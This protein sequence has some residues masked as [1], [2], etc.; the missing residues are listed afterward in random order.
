MKR[1]VDWVP[2]GMMLFPLFIGAVIRTL[3]PTAFSGDDAVFQKSFTGG[4]LTGAIPL[5]AAFY[6]CLGST[7]EFRSTGYI[8]RK[9]GALWTAKIGTAFVVAFLVRAFAAD[10]NHIVFGLSRSR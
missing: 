3:V 5:L 8:L 10:Q 4:P 6:V 2:G 7:I 1:F 9:R